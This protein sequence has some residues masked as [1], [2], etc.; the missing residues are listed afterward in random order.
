MFDDLE[1]LIVPN[2]QKQAKHTTVYKNFYIFLK[3]LRYSISV[4]D[5]TGKVESEYKGDGEKE[6]RIQAFTVI[7]RWRIQL[8]DKPPVSHNMLLIINTM[9]HVWFSTFSHTV[10]YSTH[11]KRLY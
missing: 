2:I 10:T 5:G 6:R 9:T 3:R 1:H 4:K 8:C 7:R 11:F